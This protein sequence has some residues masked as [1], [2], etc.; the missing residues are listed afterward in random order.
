MFR[1]G[2][3]ETGSA[4][5]RVGTL[6]EVADRGGRA[7]LRAK[8]NAAKTAAVFRLPSPAWMRWPT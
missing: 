3:V 8:L 5:P 4:V 2:A 7:D 6:A 1:E